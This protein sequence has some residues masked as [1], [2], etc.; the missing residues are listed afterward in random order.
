[1]V[2]GYKPSDYPADKPVPTLGSLVKRFF[3]EDEGKDPSLCHFPGCT[4]PRYKT[5]KRKG[6]ALQYSGVLC[7]THAKQM[8]RKGV[9]NITPILVNRLWHPG[10]GCRVVDC[11]RR[12]A[13]TKRFCAFHDYRVYKKGETFEETPRGVRKEVD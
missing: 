6:Q 3:G 1:M 9:A 5:R 8:Q 10:N 12:K 4:R 11:P 2:K 13:T 7:T